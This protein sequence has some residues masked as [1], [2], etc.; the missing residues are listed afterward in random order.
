MQHLVAKVGILVHQPF[1]VRLGIFLVAVL[2][3]VVPIALLV[4]VFP[5]LES[6]AWIPLYLWLLT[7]LRIWNRHIRQRELWRIYG[8]TPSR[9]CWQELGQ[10]LG[11]GIIGLYSLFILEG[12]WGWL[13]WQPVAIQDLLVFGGL[14]LFL[15]LGVSLAEELLFRGWLLDELSQDYGRVWVTLQAMFWF[16]VLHFIRPLEE[17]LRTWPQFPGLLLVAAVLILARHRTQERLA[18]PLGLHA[19]WIWGIS[20]IHNLDWIRYTQQV[21][22]WV[23]GIDNN[24]LAGLMGCGFLILTGGLIWR[25]NSPGSRH[26]AS[27]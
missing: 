6:V 17:I 7:L 27:H 24:P 14:G 11:L 9:Q 26:Q 22:A 5:P 12:S 21:P 3:G 10:G 13:T 1:P 18:L 23:T 2:L 4:V 20:V 19:G 8:L 25:I 15:G 16:A